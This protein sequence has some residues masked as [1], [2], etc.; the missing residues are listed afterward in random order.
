MNEK[1][2]SAR[3][4]ASESRAGGAR[5]YQFSRW[6]KAL[7]GVAAVL[8]TAGLGVQIVSAATGRTG[9]PVAEGDDLAAPAGAR[10]ALTGSKTTDFTGNEFWP[11]GEQPPFPGIPVPRGEH[12]KDP[13][14]S[15]AES[16]WGPSLLRGGVGF[17]IGLAVGFALRTLYK[18]SMVVIGFVL[19]AFVGFSYVGWVE[20]HWDAVQA[21]MSNW[22]T[23]IEGEFTGFKNFLLGTLPSVGLSGL[24][25]FTGFRKK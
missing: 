22:G 7:C 23:V 16:N 9:P 5:Q 12:E 1:Q 17:F 3:P 25:I 24:G 13:N 18:V 11:E 20:V 8:V 6:K 10:S 4:S 19:L 21:D 14:V 2:S 15:E